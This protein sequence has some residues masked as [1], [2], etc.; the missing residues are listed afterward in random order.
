MRPKL[1]M[2]MP[3]HPQIGTIAVVT[4]IMSRFVLVLALNCFCIHKNSRHPMIDVIAVMRPYKVS[5]CA[6]KLTTSPWIMD[7]IWLIVDIA[8]ENMKYDTIYMNEYL[9]LRISLFFGVD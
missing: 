5:S 4:M 7:V 1:S 8:S 3:K 9:S 6:E 2:L